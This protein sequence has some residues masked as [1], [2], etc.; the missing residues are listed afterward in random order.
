M[1]ETRWKRVESLF[2]QALPLQGEEREKFLAQACQDNPALYQE[3]TSLLTN[4]RSQDPF[5]EKAGAPPLHD[6]PASR[7]SAF[8]EGEKV[9]AYEIISLLG[10]GGMGEVYLARD[11]RLKRK[12]AIK[13][14]P[15][16][17]AADPGAL[18]RFQRE[19]RSASALNHPNICT[20][21]DVGEYE[22][23]PF[24]VMELLEGIALNHLIACKP[25]ETERVLAIGNDIAAALVAAHGKGI[26]HRDI[27]PANIFVTQDGQAKVLDFGLA[28]LM[29][30][31]AAGGVGA[32]TMS[33]AT[34]QGIMTVPGVPLGTFAYMS[35]EQARGK[36]LDART[37]LFS[38]GATLYEMVTGA[39][40]FRG[41]TLAEVHDAILN[42]QPTPPSRL[43]AEILPKLQEI[44][45]KCLE[46]DRSL[47]YQSAAEI[48][49]DLQRLQRDTT[50]ASDLRGAATD[51]HVGWRRRQYI[52][53]LVAFLVLAA[54]VGGWWVLRP[55][56]N[57]DS[58]AVLPFVNANA[59]PNND[60]L[61]DGITE[62]VIDA[63]SENRRLR[64]MAR[65]T[66]FR[67]KGKEQDPT[68]I[69]ANLKVAA[70]L[71]GRLT[72]RG[73]QLQIAT[74]LVKVSDGAA[75]WGEQYNRPMTDLFAVQ[76]EIARDISD[77]LKLRLSGEEQ[78]QGTRGSTQDSEA[79]DLYLRG[80]YFWNQRTP[81]SLNKSI[82]F[83]QR[84]LDK[85]PSY[86]LAW[87]GLANVYIT[88]AIYMTPL[89]AYPKARQAAERAL[90][91]DDSLAEAHS[92]MG[93][94]LGAQRE[95]A[96]AE[97][98]FKRAIE[99]D[100][101]NATT[102]YLYGFIVLAKECRLDEAVGEL[103]KS[104]ETD[105]LALAVNTN[106]GY[107]Y[108][109]QRQ[110]DRALQQYRRT[111]EIDP[112][113]TYLHMYIVEL[114]EFEGMYEKAI[115]ESRSMAGPRPLLPGVN[116]DSAD[117]LRRGYI[118]G[119]GRGYWVA[120]L[121]LAKAV[122]RKGWISPAS[123]ARI[124][125]HLGQ[126]DTAFEW[127]AKGV[128]Q[129]DEFTVEANP[130]PSFDIMR[131]DPRFATLVRKMGLEPIPLPKSQ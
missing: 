9:G 84:A 14:L 2:H 38:F 37:D 110:Y 129:Y 92:A 103:K 41:K 16:G 55:S 56:P 98:E 60:Y 125:A 93:G 86:A 54:G 97:R 82:E 89:E 88:G 75:I 7:L 72:Q 77:R 119:G 74:E 18:E 27:K 115:E 118:A 66:V 78:K 68:Q 61:S 57:I 94:I 116:R 23:K 39:L 121:E 42:R 130:N 117:V 90:R 13:I 28:K 95:W 96:G 123:M 69:G 126:M 53:A 32:T 83:F 58:I 101:R 24:L 31:Q 22:G 6:E 87:A 35:P 128:D 105:P 44:I 76:Q 71:T 108:F 26:I 91:L 50:S 8:R 29:P 109:W 3:I 34:T 40:P 81:D 80:R 67:Y 62:G 25:L 114:Y 99:L 4:Y 131:A 100:P 106:L 113:F 47:R 21:Y 107:L 64:V 85:D 48:R 102:H 36:E 11:P 104:L 1:T 49:A 51:A 112:G 30:E 12:V 33:E 65:S 63:L 73:N 17:L 45:E 20:I 5:L 15:R 43:N 124:Y 122:S 59:D 52:M 70:V 120:R 10:R 79:Y 111:Q 127:L 19:A 46:K